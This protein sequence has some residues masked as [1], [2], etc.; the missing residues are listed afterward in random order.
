MGLAGN[1]YL[2]YFSTNPGQFLFAFS[3]YPFGSLLNV[4][5]TREFPLS[6]GLRAAGK[7]AAKIGGSGP[8]AP[9]KVSSQVG[10]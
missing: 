5:L 4:A 6:L 9:H 8:S 1:S 7:V 10:L 3:R 2:P